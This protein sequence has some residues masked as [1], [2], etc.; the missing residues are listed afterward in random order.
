MFLLILAR[1]YVRHIGNLGPSVISVTN[2]VMYKLFD[3][4][5]KAIFLYL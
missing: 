4:L 3:N 5:I 2:Y 1:V